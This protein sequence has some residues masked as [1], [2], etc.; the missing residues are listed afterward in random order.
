MQVSNEKE[1]TAG[2]AATWVSLGEEML[3]G[4]EPN[5]KGHVARDPPLC[6]LGNNRAEQGGGGGGS[7]GDSSAGF[8][9]C[10]GGYTG[11]HTG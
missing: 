6:Q 9:N 10:H 7:L 8:P 2:N 11:L 4:G 5:S 1:G 3:G